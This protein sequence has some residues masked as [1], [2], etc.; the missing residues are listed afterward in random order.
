MI[1]SNNSSNEPNAPIFLEDV[2]IT[3]INGHCLTEPC[4][5]R[6]ILRLS[7]TTMPL[8]ESD[9]LPIEILDHR[10]EM[11]FVVTVEGRCDIQVVRGGGRFPSSAKGT[12]KGSL[13]LYTS[14]LT[15]KQPEADISSVS[16]SVLNFPKFNRSTELTYNDLQIELVED[17]DLYKNIEILSHTDGYAVTHTG[18]IKR[19]DSKILSVHETT[20]I[21]RMLRA[22]LSFA[23]GSGCGLTLVNAIDSDGGKT[24][25]EWGTSH[26]ETWNNARMTW[27]PMSN[28]GDCLANLFPGFWKL[29]G[30]LDWKNTLF[31]AVDWYLNANNSPFHV[32][33]V[34]AQ[35]ALES[36]CYKIVG[37][38][39]A[40]STGEYLSKS[41]QKI[42]LR[43]TIPP[44]CRNLDN[45]FKDCSRV[46]R[47]GPK[48]IAKLRNDLVHAKK[49]YHNTAEAQM[50]ALRLGL[51]YI[52]MILLKECDYHGR[53]RNRLAIAGE[54]PIENV[55]WTNGKS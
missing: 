28:G 6:I 32:G 21:L 55:P 11:P 18:Q 47:D 45:L 34:L 42:G 52:E 14:P 4:S 36:L 30:D 39:T 33:I 29:C 51:W 44:S 26:T 38:R 13:S 16:F 19:R 25:L 27:L 15:V 22:F 12:F 54:S 2:S 48:A 7:P 41:I 24:I 17:A 23:R 3:H 50:D 8:I 40:G 9:N 46:G 37:P 5:A 35:A 10:M 43:T 31:A 49:K 1:T 53:Y 20:N